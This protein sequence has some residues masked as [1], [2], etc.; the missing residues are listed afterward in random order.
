L[1]SGPANGT[2]E[3]FDPEQAG[4]I[5]DRLAGELVRTAVPDPASTGLQRDAREF[6]RF[7]RVAL[8]DQN[9]DLAFA[10][11]RLNQ[12]LPPDALAAILRELA[13]RLL[14]MAEERE[15]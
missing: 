11:P 9:S 5:L 4:I 3:W 14:D 13:E 1:G 6:L 8:S 15:V 10:V 2:S 7:L 12:D